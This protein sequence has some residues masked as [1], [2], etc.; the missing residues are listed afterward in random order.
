MDV[1]D[2]GLKVRSQVIGML[3]S[4]ISQQNVTL[5]LEVSVRSVEMWWSAIKK[6]MSLETKSRS[7]KLPF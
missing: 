5:D 7:G 6:G 3:R 2:Y 1:R 4:G